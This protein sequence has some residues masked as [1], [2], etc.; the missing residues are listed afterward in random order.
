MVSKI[1]ILKFARVNQ[2]FSLLW[3]YTLNEEV[4][5]GQQGDKRQGSAGVLNLGGV[6]T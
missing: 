2:I 3:I 1:L 4:A 5:A 6:L